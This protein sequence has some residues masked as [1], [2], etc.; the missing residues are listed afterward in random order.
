MT[1]TGARGGNR[2]AKATKWD[3]KDGRESERSHSTAEAGELVPREPG[4]GKGRLVAGPWPGNSAGALDLDPLST[5]RPRVASA[6]E[7]ATGRAGCLNWARP[8]LWEAAGATP[9]PTRPNGTSTAS[10]ERLSGSG[11]EYTRRERT[12]HEERSD[13]DH[14]RPSSCDHRPLDSAASLARTASPAADRS[15]AAGPPRPHPAR[16]GRRPLPADRR[17]RPRPQPDLRPPLARPLAGRRRGLWP[18]PRRTTS[19]TSSSSA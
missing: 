3:G 7:S 6:C 18:R 13:T 8:D 15:A 14:E 19:P 10:Q 12:S 5:K 9:P 11:G 1:N 4:G 2:L 16:P 17:P